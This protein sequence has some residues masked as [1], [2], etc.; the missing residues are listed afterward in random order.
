MFFDFQLR[1]AAQEVRMSLCLSACLSSCLSPYFCSCAFDWPYD[2]LTYL[3][4]FGTFWPLDLLTFGTFWPLGPFDLWPLDLLT[5][6]WD[7]FTFG[8]YLHYGSEEGPT[9]W[10]VSNVLGVRGVEC[11]VIPL[12]HWRGVALPPQRSSRT[13]KTLPI[14]R[15][16]IAYFLQLRDLCIWE[17]SSIILVW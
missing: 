15:A 16:Y 8:I 6:L 4:T 10:V 17:I 5:D 12:V 13:P 1:Q 11:P 3:L 9:L 7:L 2:L 14:L